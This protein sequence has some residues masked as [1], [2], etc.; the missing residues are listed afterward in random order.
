MN[1]E[2]VSEIKREEKKRRELDSVLNGGKG[3]GVEEAGRIGRGM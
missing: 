1:T 3:R 2:A